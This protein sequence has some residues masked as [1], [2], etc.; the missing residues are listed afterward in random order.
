MTIGS[1][2]AFV[3]IVDLTLLWT[4]LRFGN[5][6]WEF[7]ALSQTFTNLPLTGFGFVLLAFGLVR[8]PRLGDGWLRVAAGLFGL[9]TLLVV[10]LGALYVTVAFV[11]VRQTA[12][13]GLDS[14]GTLL[15]KNGAEIVAYGTAFAVI[16]V[17]LWRSVRKNLM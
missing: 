14:V 17:L 15:L 9:M 2:F 8:H 3:G 6:A 1:A 4:P 5:P 11:V 13:E 7:T 10:G 16:T 12:V